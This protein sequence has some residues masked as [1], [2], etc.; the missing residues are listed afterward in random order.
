MED[1]GTRRPLP[2]GEPADRARRPRGRALRPLLD[3]HRAEVRRRARPQPGAAGDRHAARE[4]DRDRAAASRPRPPSAASRR[5]RATSS[6]SPA[7]PSRLLNDAGWG[8]LVVQGKFKD[9]HFADELVEAAAALFKN[10]G[11]GA[12]ARVGDGGA[13]AAPPRA[14]PRLRRAP[15]EG[16]RPALRA[17]RSTVA[18]KTKEQSKL[19][20]SRQQYLNVQ[21]AFAVDRE[22]CLPGPV[23]LVD[24]TV[25][26]KWT[27]TEAG[28]AAA[29]GRSAR[30]VV[31]RFAL[32]L[33]AA[34]S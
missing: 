7:A 14:G 30:A 32:A 27:M 33:A 9:E 29:Q 4:A 23:L 3:L 22:T 15:G 6:S 10:W 19:E 25:D 18:K 12:G 5:S 1:Y 16:D 11:P 28:R 20:N 13:V 17:G 8:R 21:G 31:V 2:D 26:S 24:D 34:L